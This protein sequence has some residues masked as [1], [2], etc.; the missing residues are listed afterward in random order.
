[1]ESQRVGHDWAIELTESYRHFKGSWNY[2]KTIYQ[3]KWSIFRYFK[4]Q[5]NKC[6]I[7]SCER[8]WVCT[9]SVAQSCLT[10]RDRMDCSPPGSS[11]HRILQA[12]IL[13]WVAMPSSRGS[14]QP[15]DWI[16]VLLCLLPWQ[17]DSLSPVPPGKPKAL[18]FY[19]YYIS[20]TSDH[21]ALDARGWGPLP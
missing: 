21:Q 20:S 15:R 7:G 5:G 11:V 17:A 16:H 14:S 13:E 1:M 8:Y 19:Y 18:Y 3:H 10:L 2:S 9:C 6:L 12:R 4:T